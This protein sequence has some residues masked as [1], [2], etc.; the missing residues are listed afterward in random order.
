MKD[1]DC[2]REAVS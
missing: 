2:I 1:L